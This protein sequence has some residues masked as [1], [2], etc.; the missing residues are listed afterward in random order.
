MSSALRHPWSAVFVAFGL[1][2]FAAGGLRAESSAAEDPRFRDGCSA[3]DANPARGAAPGGWHVLRPEGNAA[4]SPKGFCSWLW[5]IGAFS[6]GNEYKGSPPPLGCIGGRDLPLT[7]DALAAVSNTLANARANGAVMI[8]RFGYTSGA[9]TGAEPTDFNVL[10]GHVRQLGRVLGAFPDVVLAVECGM[11]GPWGEMH[12]NG[13]REPHH[14]RAIG[15]AW[16]ETLA[17]QTALLVRYPMW[18]T[19]YAGKTSGEF[20]REIEDGTYFKKQPAQRRIGMFNDGY[21]GTDADYGTWRRGEKWMVREQGVRYLEARRNV[22]YG[23]E[24]AHISE[25]EAEAVPLFDLAKFNVV[26]EFYRTHLSYLRNIDAKRHVL[27][28]RIGRL[29]LT[30]DYDFAGMPDL[31]EWYGT[32]LR[33]FMRT[34]MGY[35]FVVRGVKFGDG[36]VEVTIENTGF[37]HLLMKNRAEIAVGASVRPVSLDLRKIRPGE[38]KSFSLPLPGGAS[39][40]ADPVLTVRL[41]TPAAQ[42][43][44]FANDALRAGEGIRLARARPNGTLR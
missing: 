37:G 28:A 19:E 29:A 21:L 20:L 34:H 42:V 27:A 5:N 6:G 22:P 15:D 24:L 11:T 3:L 1:G 41:E 2:A 4:G 25:E 39:A 17:K 13:Y 36:A 43:V 33:T 14:I 8:V 30:H 38:R 10:V 9:E 23:G 35:R 32:D 12:S 16:L 18:V 26:H 40:G 44:H 7:D 31:S